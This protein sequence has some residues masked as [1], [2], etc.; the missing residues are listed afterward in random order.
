MLNTEL[1]HTLDELSR[2]HTKIV[3]LRAESAEHRHQE[4]GSL[5]PQGLISL[6]ARRPM[7][8]MCMAP[9]TIGPR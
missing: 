1:D 7:V 5:A 9:S 4:G 6:I 2:A 8:I 3:V